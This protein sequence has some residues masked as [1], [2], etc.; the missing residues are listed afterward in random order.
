MNV[1]FM[2]GANLLTLECSRDRCIDFGS[3]QLC[4]SDNWKTDLDKRNW[5]KNLEKDDLSK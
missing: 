5:N 1:T 2:Y 3:T 4:N